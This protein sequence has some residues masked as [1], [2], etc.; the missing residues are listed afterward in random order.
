MVLKQ[1]KKRS[2][3]H[4]N[5]GQHGGAGAARLPRRSKA[6]ASLS[7]FE[8]C[9]FSEGTPV[10]IHSPKKLKLDNRLIEIALW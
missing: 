5:V 3:H 9:M 6:L 10:S 4:L 2:E 1:E 7:L 8:V